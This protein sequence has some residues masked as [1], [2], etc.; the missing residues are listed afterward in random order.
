M[1]FP[2]VFETGIKPELTMYPTKSEMERVGLGTSRAERKQYMWT[3]KTYQHIDDIDFERFINPKTNRPFRFYEEAQNV[4]EVGSKVVNQVGNVY[5]SK[6]VQFVLDQTGLNAAGQIFTEGSISAYN[7]T[8]Q[9]VPFKSQIKQGASFALD[10]SEEA[11]LGLSQ[12]ADVHPLFTEIGLTV[13]EAFGPGAAKNIAKKKLV[14]NLNDL[15]KLVPSSSQVAV[16]GGGSFNTASVFNS[17]DTTGTFT[18]GSVS[19]NLTNKFKKQITSIIDKYPVKPQNIGTKLPL[20][21]SEGTARARNKAMK[22]A[23]IT[24]YTDEFGHVWKLEGTKVKQWRNTDLRKATKK[25]VNPFTEETGSR[26][27]ST[28]ASTEKRLR[29]LIPSSPEEAKYI[30]DI[31][32]EIATMN[33]NLGLKK[34]HPDFMTL[35]HRI[36]QKDWKRLNLP[37]NPA[38]SANLWITKQYEAISKTRI[39]NIIRKRKSI[40]GEYIVNFN[41]QNNSLVVTKLKEFNLHDIPKG[42]RFKKNTK[43]LYNWDEINKYLDKLE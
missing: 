8:K 15:T 21:I 14:S 42:K 28:R 32:K 43:G 1:S 16:A 3:G 18:K 5:N 2:E 22:A 36:A 6:P 41:P 25:T 30:A 12:K 27:G 40:K 26:L 34:G 4:K 24:T 17:I 33:K 37:G 31:R 35:E 38:D 19:A 13:I 29:D 9:F 23:G 20:Y 11:L 7:F 10:K 39:E